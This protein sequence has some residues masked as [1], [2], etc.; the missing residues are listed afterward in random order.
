MK[1]LSDL[2]IRLEAKGFTT[3]LSGD[4]LFINGTPN[5]GK[6]RYGFLVASDTGGTGSC[7][8]IVKRNGEISKAVRESHEDAV[9]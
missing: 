9:N 1:T 2:A 3:N 6:S 8:G 5:G 7:N 4:R